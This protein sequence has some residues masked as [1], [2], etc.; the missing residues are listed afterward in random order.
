MLDISRPAQPNEA[1]YFRS[2]VIGFD[3]FAVNSAG[4]AFSLV[5]Y[6]S[7]F[8]ILDC[9][10]ALTSPTLLSLT[11]YHLS[12]QTFPNPFNSRTTITFDLPVSVT[13]VQ[14]VVNLGIYDPLG[15][16]VQDL[17]PKGRMVSGKR[18]VVWNCGSLCAGKYYVELNTPEG[19]LV[20][21]VV[22]VK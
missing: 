10:Q 20:K 7:G 11:P 5:G 19:R 16:L 8:Y 2:D 9:R 22:L 12:L 14:S 6:P 1:G 13:S 21:P 18:S 4:Y 17:T 15:R 3:A